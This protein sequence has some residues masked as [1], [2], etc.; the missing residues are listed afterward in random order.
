MDANQRRFA[1]RN[2]CRRTEGCRANAR[3]AAALSRKL[4]VATSARLVA[5]ERRLRDRT[6]ASIVCRGGTRRAPEAANGMRSSRL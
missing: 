1:A 6:A 2:Y 3:D 4:N 5:T